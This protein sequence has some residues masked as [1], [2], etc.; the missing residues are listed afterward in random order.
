MLDCRLTITKNSKKNASHEY[1]PEKAILLNIWVKRKAHDIILKTTT[2]GKR[3]ARPA[4]Q[5]R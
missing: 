5:Q 4:Q 1:H 3:E 2:L